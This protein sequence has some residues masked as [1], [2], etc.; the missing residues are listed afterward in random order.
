MKS[1]KIAIAVMLAFATTGIT[2]QIVKV[3]KTYG[4]TSNVKVQAAA[5]SAPV[6]AKAAPANVNYYYLPDINTY[7][8]APAKV[9][10]YEREG[11]WVRTSALP[12]RYRG[13]NLA[14]GRTVYLTDYRGNTP[15]TLYKVHKVKYKGKEWKR[16]GHDNGKHKGHHKGKGHKK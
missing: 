6:W 5:A 4:N 3:D 9:Y 14:A 12:A 15:Y 2:A 13:Y 8:D 7:Y 16:N 10:I 1:I 11:K